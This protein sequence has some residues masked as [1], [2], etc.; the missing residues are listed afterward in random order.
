MY[1][2]AN[3]EGPVWGIGLTPED[4]WNDA[5]CFYECLAKG[6]AG[7]YKT[8]E[9]LMKAAGIS[10]GSAEPLNLWLVECSK[11]AYFLLERGHDSSEVSVVGGDPNFGGKLKVV[12]WSELG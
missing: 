3:P 7:Y 5:A 11:E 1:A 12:A 9:K 10:A 6:G 4:A 8:G 2:V